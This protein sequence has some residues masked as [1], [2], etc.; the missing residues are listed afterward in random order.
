[1][2]TSAL[3]WGYFLAYLRG[4]HS[5]S[6]NPKCAVSQMFGGDTWAMVPVLDVFIAVLRGAKSTFLAKYLIYVMRK[7]GLPH[8]TNGKRT[9]QYL[10]LISDKNF[11]R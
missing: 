7:A 2:F 1:M 9:I 4:K 10:T 6:R 5:A 11:Q 8:S 3:M